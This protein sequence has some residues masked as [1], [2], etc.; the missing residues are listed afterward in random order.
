MLGGGQVRVSKDRQDAA[1]QL[2]EDLT[3]GMIVIQDRGSHNTRQKYNGG[4]LYAHLEKSE[5]SL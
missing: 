3:Q 2:I 5:T 1:I 4:T